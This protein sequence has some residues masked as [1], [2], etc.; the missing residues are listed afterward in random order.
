M[1]GID[2]WIRFARR[3][4]AAIERSFAEKKESILFLGPI[5]TRA[6]DALA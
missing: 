3:I 5:L 6:T 2:P 1:R 4:V